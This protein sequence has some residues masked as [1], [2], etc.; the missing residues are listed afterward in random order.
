MSSTP[1]KEMDSGDGSV[2]TPIQEWNTKRKFTDFCLQADSGE[3][4]KCH[5]ERL[6]NSSSFFSLMLENEYLETK[7]NCMQVPKFKPETILHCLEYIYTDARE[8]AA[9]EALK[10]GCA[11]TGEHI[12]NKG[13]NLEKFTPELLNMAHNYDLIDLKE[14]CIHYLEQNI[15][16]ENAVG[17][18]MS[19]KRC[20]NRNL[21]E[22]AM[23]YLVEAQINEPTSQV[24]GFEDIENSNVLMKE[25]MRFA[26]HDMHA[27]KYTDKYQTVVLNH[28][29][30]GIENSG[31]QQKENFAR[32]IKTLN[33]KIKEKP[34]NI[35]FLIFLDTKEKAEF[36]SGIM[37]SNEW[38]VIGN[39]D[40]GWSQ[41]EKSEAIE[42]FMSGKRQC[43]IAVK[44]S[45]RELENIKAHMVVN[46]DF[47]DSMEEY[48]RRIKL[49]SKK[50]RL[51]SYFNATQDVKLIRD[52]IKVLL[53][54]KQRVS[55]PLIQ[56]WL[57]YESPQA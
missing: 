47:P 51:T 16:D 56:C 48:D 27:K 38:N 23:K 1:P 49:V 34:V 57:N 31:E 32:V 36:V 26:F 50:G 17:A 43:L 33:E 8:P 41:E 52:L 9:M 24:L 2:R 37:N 40:E 19:S 35:G 18:W 29:S 54:A 53:I 22:S 12:Y 21:E 13:F 7:N 11:Q 4:F 44:V 55:R 45:A 46:Y 28:G 5:K 14:D 20:R 39:M 10:K 42:K 6:A 15:S 30:C 3:E 25:L